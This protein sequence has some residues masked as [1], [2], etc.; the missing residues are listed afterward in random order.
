MNF[1]EYEIQK[2]ER[3]VKKIGDTPDPTKL[4]SNKLLYEMQRNEMQGWLD[5][6][7]KGEPFAYTMLTE[8]ILETMGFHC[9]NLSY[10]SDRAGEQAERYFRI[11]RSAGFPE[12]V[13]DRF[14][15]AMGMILNGDL[16]KPSFVAGFN[17]AC[18][19]EPEIL[20]AAAHFTGA[21]FFHVDRYIEPDEEPIDY[22]A[23]QLRD[24]VAQAETIPG[25][26]KFDEDK[27]GE[28]QEKMKF[29]QSCLKVLYEAGKQVPCPLR[30][31]DAFR[32]PMLSW[33]NK[34]GA[35]EYF[36]SLRDEMI[37]RVEKKVGVL[38]EEKARALWCVT[39]PYFT[40]AMALLEKHG[41][42][43]PLFEWDII[44]GF[45]GV[46]I[47]AIGDTTELGRKLSP[48]E[49][50]ARQM[51]LT[52]WAGPAQRWVDEILYHCREF[53][54]DMLIYYMLSGCPTN[55]LSA[56]IVA[57]EVEKQLGIPT[58]FLEGYM[59]DTEKYNP[60]EME[61]KLEEFINVAL[62]KKALRS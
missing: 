26:R 44:M 38:P 62:R 50:Y 11:A 8:P 61:T 48:L 57:D 59:L 34:P 28:S 60:T 18:T 3:R 22:L 46:G 25:V 15:V 43:V 6:W 12:N 1:L 10:I 32:I 39:G 49:E 27:L 41:V 40:N 47:G 52:I 13:C 37:A 29:A 17:G 42:S 55:L 45:Y 51:R 16:P 4:R 20:T 21:P 2:L 58:L 14:Q 30:G 54:I 36:T 19:L 31:Q 23:A 24:M 7:R 33:A 53:K 56:K 5:G 9:I 35:M